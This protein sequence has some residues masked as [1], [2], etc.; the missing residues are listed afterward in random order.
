[1]NG[2]R[3]F[4]VQ[5]AST[6]GRAQGRLDR[7]VRAEQVAAVVARLDLAEARV[8]GLVERV[9]GVDPALG[10]VEI[11]AR[12][13][14]LQHLAYAREVRADRLGRARTHGDPD[15]VQAVAGVERGERTRIGGR[16]V[17]GPP[18]L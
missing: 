8:G 14:R 1:M 15:A 10:E 6:R 3:S 16:L 7:V 5:L 18:Q 9:R 4:T 13:P 17:Q 11:A 12:C 2:A